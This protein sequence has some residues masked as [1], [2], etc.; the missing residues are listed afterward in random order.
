MNSKSMEKWSGRFLLMSLL[1]IIYELIA[2]TFSTGVFY[3]L[4][5]ALI[6]NVGASIMK[7]L[8]EIMINII[9]NGDSNNEWITRYKRYY[10]D[11][12]A[13]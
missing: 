8:E 3:F 11:A 5:A 4:L 2:N 13:G 9:N 6:F 1:A 10:R 7:K 12:M